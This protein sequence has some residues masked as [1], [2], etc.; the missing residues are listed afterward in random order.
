MENWTMDE[1]ALDGADHIVHLSVRAGRRD[2][3]YRGSKK[4]GL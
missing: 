3:A 2:T 1:K 4:I